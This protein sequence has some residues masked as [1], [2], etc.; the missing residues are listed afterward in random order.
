MDITGA[1]VKAPSEAQAK[2]DWRLSAAAATQ[3][4]R[5]GAYVRATQVQSAAR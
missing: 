5:E 2:H 3:L 1:V 4:E